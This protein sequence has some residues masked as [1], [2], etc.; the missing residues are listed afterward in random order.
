MEVLRTVEDIVKF[1]QC[2]Q[3]RLNAHVTSW[4]V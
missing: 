4:N 2:I 3:L 1:K